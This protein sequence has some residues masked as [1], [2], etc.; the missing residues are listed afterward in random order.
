MEVSI[1]LSKCISKTNIILLLAYVSFG[2]SKFHLGCKKCFKCQC[3]LAGEYFTFLSNDYCISHRSEMI[4][5]F[6][7]DGLIE[8]DEIVYADDNS[9]FFHVEHFRCNMCNTP[10]LQDKFHEISNR[11]T[12]FRCYCN[13][14]SANSDGVKRPANIPGR[15]AAID[16]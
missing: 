7:C 15:E 16:E 12:C 3:P 14:M 5:C 10:L 9:K 6:N 1:Q 8:D 13:W 11:A 4:K 2:S